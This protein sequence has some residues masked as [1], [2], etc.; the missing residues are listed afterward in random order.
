MPQKRLIMKSPRFTRFSNL[1]CCVFTMAPVIY[2][3]ASKTSAQTRS[4][5][6][7]PLA[8]SLLSV[9]WACWKELRR[10]AGPPG[11]RL[12]TE[13]GQGCG[14]QRGEGRSRPQQKVSSGQFSEAKSKTCRRALQPLCPFA[15]RPVS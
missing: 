15:P 11:H 14:A 2:K 1:F 12:R 8:G 7:H 4:A 5:N 9:A 10:A 13:G 6:A 3:D